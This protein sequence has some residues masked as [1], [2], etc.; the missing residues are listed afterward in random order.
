ML[1]QSPDQIFTAVTKG[2]EYRYASPNK[3][4]NTL[5]EYKRALILD[6]RAAEAFH[7]SHFMCSIN[8]PHSTLSA[9]D[10]VSYDP[11]KFAE[12][13][14]TTSKDRELFSQRR[15]LVVFL[16]PAHNSV[17]PLCE[18]ATEFKKVLGTTVQTDKNSHLKAKGLA[19]ACLM[20]GCFRQE[21]I[22]EAYI[23]HA[24]FRNLL[25]LYP[26]L[27]EFCDNKIYVEP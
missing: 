14:L 20:F 25:A 17:K 22:R 12:K 9:S 27:C 11:A 7:R 2:A 1:G 26:F 21:K 19:I 24:G 8:I 16:I 4:F 5:Q 23:V 10:F 15:R 18:S 13:H 3:V 6:F